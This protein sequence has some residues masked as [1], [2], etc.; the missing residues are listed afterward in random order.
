LDTTLLDLVESQPCCARPDLMKYR[1]LGLEVEE[2]VEVAMKLSSLRN[3][4]LN[5][6]IEG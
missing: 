6:K 1:N 3:L 4:G 2:I 5:I